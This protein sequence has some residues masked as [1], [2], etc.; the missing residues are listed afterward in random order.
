MRRRGLS[1][2][3]LALL[4]VAFTAF[5]C[6]SLFEAPMKPGMG[7][8]AGEVTLA[9]AESVEF[10]GWIVI[11]LKGGESRDLRGERP[12]PL[13]RGVQEFGPTV[14]VVERT[15]PIRL[16][17]SDRIEHRYFSRSAPNEVELPFLAPGESHELRFDSPGLVRF[18]CSEHRGEKMP[19][20]VTPGP[21][22]VLLKNPGSYAIEDVPPGHYELKAIGENGNTHSIA[23]QVESGKSARVQV[24]LG[25]NSP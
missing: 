2:G 18:E 19:I 12:E 5:G 17:N 20:I 21:H 1:R 3:G 16:L 22:F 6:R 8:V 4:A 24:P 10:P 9:Y 14:L 23:V 7:R 15:R 13:W 25:G 11:Y